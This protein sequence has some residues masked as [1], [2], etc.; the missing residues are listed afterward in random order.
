MPTMVRESQISFVLRVLSK[1]EELEK[2]GLM[3][4]S[5]IQGFRLE[6]IITSKP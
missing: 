4:T 1:G 2:D 5:R 6:S 3:L